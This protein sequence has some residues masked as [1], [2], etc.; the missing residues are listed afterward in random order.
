M[1]DIPPLTIS[2]EEAARALGIG[3]SLAYD[4]VNKGTIPTIALGARRV[5][6]VK[7]LEQKVEEWSATARNAG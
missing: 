7:L 3:K 1:A 5:V 6:P 4:L 2:I